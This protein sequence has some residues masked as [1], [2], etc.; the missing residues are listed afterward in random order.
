MSA[1]SLKEEAIGYALMFMSDTP[2]IWQNVSVEHQIIYQRLLFPKGIPYN[3][4][5]NKFGTADMS[6]L[7]SLV[8]TQKD[9]EASSDNF[10]VISPGIEPGLP[11]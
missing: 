6:P 2:R 8:A 4:Q 7:Y 11:G 1:M 3:L 9:A 10:L 5:T